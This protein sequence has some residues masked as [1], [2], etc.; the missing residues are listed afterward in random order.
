MD[1]EREVLHVCCVWGTLGGFRGSG[2][3]VYLGR[4]EK[5]RFKNSLDSGGAGLESR[6]EGLGLFTGNI[7][8]GQA[9]R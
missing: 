9:W 2:S 1:S 4:W 6:A 5:V 7:L 8:K 3:V